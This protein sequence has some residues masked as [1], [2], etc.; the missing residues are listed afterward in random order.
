MDAAFEGW[1]LFYQLLGLVLKDYI[2]NKV[3]WEIAGFLNQVTCPL[4]GFIYNYIASESRSSDLFDFIGCS[5][6]KSKLLNI[7]FAG[8][9]K[10]K[11]T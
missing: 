6:S 5:K 2:N 10:D 9:S 1:N 7:S 3:P 4:Y 11:N 8:K